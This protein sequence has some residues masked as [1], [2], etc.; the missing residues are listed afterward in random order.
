MRSN[1]PTHA[2]FDAM[3]VE[4]PERFHDFKLFLLATSI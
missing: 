2:L 4:C 1:L 3:R